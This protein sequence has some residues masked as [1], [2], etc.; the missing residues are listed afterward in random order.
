MIGLKTKSKKK[1]H[2][3][4]KHCGSVELNERNMLYGAE[5]SM[6]KNANIIQNELCKV[7]AYGNNINTIFFSLHLKCSNC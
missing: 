3:K 1:N 4:K 7:R 2:K 6:E 5:A